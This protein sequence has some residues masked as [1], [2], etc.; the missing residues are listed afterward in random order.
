MVDFE[1]VIIGGGVMGAS[2]AFH[3]T[4]EGQKVCL[5]EWRTVASG[6]TGKSSALVRTHYS[7]ETVA[8]MA[9]YSLK[10]FQHY[11][12][13]GFTKYTK[14]GMIFPFSGRDADI[15]LKNMEMLKSIGVD[16]RIVDKQFLIDKYGNINT[17]KFDLLLYEPE[18]GYADPVATTNAFMDG[19]KA[20]GCSIIYGEAVKIESENGEVNVTLSG[21]KSLT[22]KKVIIATNVWTNRLLENSGIKKIYLPPIHASVHGIIYLRRPKEMKGVKPTLWDPPNRLYYKMEGESMIVIGSIDPSLDRKSYDVF[23]PLNERMEQDEIIEYLSIAINRLPDL[24]KGTLIDNI[25]GYYDMTPDGQPII[26]SLDHTGLENCFICAGFSGHGFKLSPAIG[27]IVFDMVTEKDP[28][29]SMFDWRIF[30]LKRF[31][32]GNTIKSL[33]DDIGTIY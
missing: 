16:E 9:L 18:S 14:N 6:N 27:K 13:T 25:R 19:A 11:D 26:D 22:G 15:A 12:S 32:T 31:V 21:G 23:E 17:D 3:L 24:G 30:S 29:K 1:Y 20:A 8:R 5:V 10:S 7:N 4:R 33:Y 28:E 2:I